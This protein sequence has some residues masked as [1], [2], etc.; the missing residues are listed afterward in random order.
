MKTALGDLSLRATQTYP[1][2]AAPVSVL[3]GCQKNIIIEHFL[4]IKKLIREQRYH[5]ETA[6]KISN[7]IERPVLIT[8]TDASWAC[9][10]DGSS[11]GGQLT[12]LADM[13]V[14]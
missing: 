14:L 11:Q 4:Q 12:L 3:Q 5:C 10:M 13:G 9:R 8:Y 2:I 7:S 6:L 1:W